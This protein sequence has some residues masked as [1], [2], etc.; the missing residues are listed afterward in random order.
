MGS[1]QVQ[2]FLMAVTTEQVVDSGATPASPMEEQLLLCLM[3]KEPGNG[4]PSVLRVP[5]LPAGMAAC[6]F[7]EQLP[8]LVAGIL[9]QQDR[10]GGVFSSTAGRRRKEGA[11]HG[12]TNTMEHLE[13]KE[14]C[15]FQR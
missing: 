4:T 14:R 2:V 12:D 13:P 8:K 7:L 10:A 3:R 1:G 11:L 6:S 5:L 15:C 9:G